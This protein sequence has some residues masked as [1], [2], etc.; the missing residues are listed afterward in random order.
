M[1][2]DLSFTAFGEQQFDYIIAQ[3]VLTH[4]PLEDIEETFRN[5]S[6]V[7]HEGSLFFAT[8]FDGGKRT[9]TTQDRLNFYYP[10]ET[11]RALGKQHGLAVT[12]APAYQHPREQQMMR[13]KI[14][15][16][17]LKSKE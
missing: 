16:Q 12:R 15:D 4:M 5:I 13:V 1:T 3:S 11:L 9:Y 17:K 6:R 2:S 7:M 14:A 8:F 10:F